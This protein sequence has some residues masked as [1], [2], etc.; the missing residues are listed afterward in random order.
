[1]VV[2]KKRQRNMNQMLTENFGTLC[3]KMF[4]LAEF[5]AVSR[6]HYCPCEDA[7]NT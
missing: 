1:M 4:G 6:A 2:P 5:L 7:H 3:T